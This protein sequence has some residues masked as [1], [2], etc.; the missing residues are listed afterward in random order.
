MEIRWRESRKK[1]IFENF[2]KNLNFFDFFFGKIIFRNF[3]G[4]DTFWHVPWSKWSRLRRDCRDEKIFRKFFS[5]FF[6]MSR[7]SWLMTSRDIRD[8]VNMTSVVIFATSRC[9]LSRANFEKF[10]FEK[11]QI[12]FNFAWQRRENFKKAP[13]C[14]EFLKISSIKDRTDLYDHLWWS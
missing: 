14:V 9:A 4:H 2:S 12:F 10:I 5:N 6:R 13:H 1:F 11:I 3:F 7:A 8:V